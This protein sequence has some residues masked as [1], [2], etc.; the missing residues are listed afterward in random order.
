MLAKFEQKLQKLKERVS[1][2]QLNLT[3]PSKRPTDG[4]IQGIS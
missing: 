2:F 1:D 4:Q 3:E